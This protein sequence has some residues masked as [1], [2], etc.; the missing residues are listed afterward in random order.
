VCAWC[1]CVWCVVCVVCGT[2]KTVTQGRV[3]TAQASILRDLQRWRSLFLRAT[4]DRANRYISVRPTHPHAGPRLISQLARSVCSLW[5]QCIA[6]IIA[7]RANH[8][9]TSPRRRA[10]SVCIPPQRRAGECSTARYA[11]PMRGHDITAEVGSY[12]SLIYL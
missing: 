11:Q 7:D 4:L 1:V 2:V 10:A 3:N 12:W 5:Y 6:D 9:A 8:Y